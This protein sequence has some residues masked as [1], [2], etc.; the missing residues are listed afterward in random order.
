MDKPYNGSL[1][2]TL[3][4]FTEKLFDLAKSVRPFCLLAPLG[5]YP[6]S[7]ISSPSG[8]ENIENNQS[9]FRVPIIPEKW[10]EVL[11]VPD[12]LLNNEDDFESY[13]GITNVSQLFLN[14]YLLERSLNWDMSASKTASKCNICKRKADDSIILCDFCNGGFHPYCLT[15]PVN[16]VND[17]EGDWYC[18]KCLGKQKPKPPNKNTE[19]RKLSN[20]NANIKQE[21]ETANENGNVSATKSENG[22]LDRCKFCSELIFESYS[23]VKKNQIN[24]ITTNPFILFQGILQNMCRSFSLEMCQS[25][26]STASM[27][28]FSLSA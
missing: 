3:K 18:Y 25:D 16:S 10:F 7:I 2:D 20:A 22:L 19:M 21:P 24:P 17:I 11:K 1:Y 23:E 13:F 9:L 6:D 14:L 8:K 27:E 4:L 5:V 26:P 28:L 12:A 15:P